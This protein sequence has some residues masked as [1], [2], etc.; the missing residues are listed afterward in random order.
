MSP[1]VA[2]GVPTPPSVDTSRVA[3]SVHSWDEFTQLREVIVGSAAGARLPPATDISAWLNLYPEMTR[4]EVVGA[5]WGPVPDRIVDEAE[6][7]LEA[8]QRTLESLAVTVQRP[9]PVDHDK[10]FSTRDWRSR[11]MYSYC[12]RDL[13]LV[14]GDAL[15]ECPSATRARFFENEGLRRHFARYEAR[16][17][18]WISAPR[19]CLADELYSIDKHGRPQLGE[20]EIAFEAANILR[21]GRDILYQVSTSGNEAGLRWLE[22]TVQSLGNFRV[23][24]LR[25]I[26][27]YTH[28]DST[29]SVLRPGLVLLNPERVS[30]EAVPS[31]FEKW[32]KI[33][34]PTP[35]HRSH[36]AFDLSSPWIAMNLL[37]V[38]PDTAIVDATQ[39]ELHRLLE[40]KRITVVPHRMRH[41]AA[42]GGGIHCVTLDIRRDGEL[43]DYNE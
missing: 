15:I 32:D 7:D 21:I 11:G 18:R 9:D 10:E 19:P 25:G 24:P 42:L 8:L 1:Q 34:C 6:E 38:S 12:P 43:L 23:H 16:G 29:I 35:V 39:T 26:Y 41:Q 33:W 28:I 3:R 5:P 17:A 22:R 20:S 40:K 14:L 31:I 2:E 4:D 13:T 30:P 36:N 37:M 27:R